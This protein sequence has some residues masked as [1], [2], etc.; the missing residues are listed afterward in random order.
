MED[1]IKKPESFSATGL[2]VSFVPTVQEVQQKVESRSGARPLDFTTSRSV[3]FLP[4]NLQATVAKGGK[5]HNRA[6]ARLRVQIP[7]YDSPL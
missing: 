2:D 4:K 3:L 1:I 6:L 7:A 5:Q